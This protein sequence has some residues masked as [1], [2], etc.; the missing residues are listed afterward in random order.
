MEDILFSYWGATII[1]VLGVLAILVSRK[2]IY[3]K[4]TSTG[5][6]YHGMIYGGIFLI[7]VSFMMF[8]FTYNNAWD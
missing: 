3:K 8:Y 7:L 2:F 1:F 5:N 6:H 4:A